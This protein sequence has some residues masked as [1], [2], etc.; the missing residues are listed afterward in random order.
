MV[1]FFLA[2]FRRA[3]IA[4]AII[5]LHMAGTNKDAGEHEEGDYDGG[6]DDD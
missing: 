2:S 3:F 4:K 1:R 6:D 5:T